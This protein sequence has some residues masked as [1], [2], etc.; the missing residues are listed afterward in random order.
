MKQG[1]KKGVYRVNRLFCEKLV[2]LLNH[3][4]SPLMDIFQADKNVRMQIVV[5][6]DPRAEKIEITYFEED[7]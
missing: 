4:T 5:D 3:S 2:A 6:Y 1:R 7:I